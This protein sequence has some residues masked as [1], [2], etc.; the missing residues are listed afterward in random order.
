MTLVFL[1]Q[2]PLPSLKTYVT[3]SFLL[4]FSSLLYALNN[5][6]IYTKWTSKPDLPD[7]TQEGTEPVVTLYEFMTVDNFCFWSNL[8]LA[9]CCLF[10]FGKVIQRVVFGDLR[11]AELQLSFS[12]TTTPATH[13]K[14]I[15]L[16]VVLLMCCNGLFFLSLF[17]GWP[18]G[19]HTFTFMLAE[20]SHMYTCIL[21]LI[22]IIHVGIRY[23]IHLW[24][25]GHVG[26]WEGRTTWCY[27]TDLLLDLGMYAVDLIHHLHMLLWSN[28][29][30]SMASLVLCMQ[31]RHLF[32]EIK[33]RLARHRNFVR[34]LQCMEKRF[35]L[36]TSEELLA[37]NDDCAICW[38]TLEVARKLPCNHI[39]HSSCLRSWLEN[40][41]SC[42][43]CRQ[44][45]AEDLQPETDQDEERQPRGM[46][47]FMM[48]R[49]NR[50]NHF[51]H[52][53]GTQ[54]ASWF[55]SFS[56]E[57]VHTHANDPT[58]IQQLPESRLEL[59]E[60]PWKG[61]LANFTDVITN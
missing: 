48:G 10:I 29:F 12:P 3:V 11:E 14:I 24:D 21:L 55:P 42:P 41:T 37:N 47:A 17:V 28:I 9:Y 44:S 19:I 27:Y 51:F 1:E 36:A 56:V 32:Y 33:K 50:R 6:T 2:L 31:L 40:D 4:F 22:K 8:N 38:D 61:E 18:D 60:I 20:V 15:G 43:T 7:T 30:L 39:F 54:I 57:V 53:D 59:M 16:L 5:A 45:L 58:D 13:S 34:I 26:T 25:V 49:G 52:F 35:P 23:G 46:A